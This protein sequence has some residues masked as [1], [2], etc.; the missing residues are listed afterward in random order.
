MVFASCAAKEDKKIRQAEVKNIGEQFSIDNVVDSSGNK[1]T[2]DFSASDITIIDFWNNGCPPCIEEM[3]QFPALIKGKAAKVS[4]LSISLTQYWLWKPTLQEHK[5]TFAF[6][7]YDVPNWKQYNLLTT[8]DPR[9]KNEISTDRL[10][11]LS[12]RYGINFNPA[13]VVV[14]RSGKILARP[15]SA[16]EYL[17]EPG[18]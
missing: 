13:Y 4:I 9:L 18:L 2:L 7:E 11:E 8:D 15:E 16:V 17:K 10:G 3:K 1:I 12:S 14:D 5:G 6:L